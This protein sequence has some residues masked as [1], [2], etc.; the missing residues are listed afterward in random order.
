MFLV[1]PWKSEGNGLVCKKLKP[2]T[3]GFTPKKWGCPSNFPFSQ[4]WEEGVSCSTSWISHDWTIMG[5]NCR[6]FFAIYDG[7]F[8]NMPK[9]QHVSVFSR[10]I[11]VL[12]RLTH[13]L[14]TNSSTQFSS[15]S[16]E[17]AWKNQVQTPCIHRGTIGSLLSGSSKTQQLLT[18][19][20]GFSNYLVK[21][22]ARQGCSWAT[23]AA[24][25]TGVAHRCKICP[26]KC[27]QI[28]GKAPNF[29]I[30]R[31]G[32]I[33]WFLLVD[34]SPLGLGLT[35]LEKPTREPNDSDLGWLPI[36]VN[37]PKPT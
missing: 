25:I 8:A 4:F 21:L 30:K 23:S 14:I 20:T 34:M 10:S 1:S 7:M 15:I 35:F 2:E 31:I 11:P 29:Q 5:K 33:W 17:T 36:W 27:R 9:C 16:F 37:R 6:D 18:C 3:I 22:L 19:P 12:G 13:Y 32:E 26:W 24:K 28:W